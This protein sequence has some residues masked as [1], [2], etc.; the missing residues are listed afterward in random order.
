MTI[1]FGLDINP[2]ANEIDEIFQRAKLADRL[3]F[4][5]ISSQ[6]HPYNRHFLDTWTMLSALSSVTER[7]MLLSNVSNLP[8]RPPA[9]LA[10]QAASLD[11]LSGGRVILG[12]GAGGFWDAVAA[13]G[14]PRRSPGE[15]YRAFEEALHII[16]SMFTESSF[17]FEGEFYTIKGARPGPKPAHDIEIWTGALGPKMLHLTGEMADGVTLSH[18]YAPPEKLP[19]FNAQIDAGAQAA[20]RSPDAIWRNY[21]LMGTIDDSKRTMYPKEGIHGPAE[22]WVEKLIWLHEDYRQNSFVFWPTGDDAEAQIETF[23]NEVIPAVR[24]HVA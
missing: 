13:Y 19:W 12:I 9:M 20:G 17:S 16:R 1:R 8:L 24:S 4:D 3:G 14:G 15:A 5:F 22:F 7:V 23:A 10:K 6:D 11:V 21:N 18:P 2:A